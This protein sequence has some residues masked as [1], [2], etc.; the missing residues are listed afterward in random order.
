MYYSA[1]DKQCDCYFS[2]GL[3]SETIEECQEEIR[4]YLQE[5]EVDMNRYTNQQILDI[6]EVEIHSHENLM[7]NDHSF[8]MQSDVITR[9]L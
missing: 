4:E 3:N 2:T 7:T 5:G 1:Y 9:R 6:F 8:N